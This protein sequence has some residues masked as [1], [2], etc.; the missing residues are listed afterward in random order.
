MVAET[1]NFT[2]AAE[3]LDVSQPSI[4]QQIKEIETLL[5]TV[6]FDRLGARVRLTQAGIAFRERAAEVV[7]KFARACEVV[8][9]VEGLLLGHVDVGVIPAVQIPWIPPVLARFAGEH[10]GVSIRVHERPSSDVETEV[11]AGRYDVGVGLM[12]RASPNLRYERIRIDELVLLA[13]SNHPLARRRDVQLRDLEEVRLALHPE[14]YPMRQMIEDAFRKARVR[15]RVAFEIDTIDSL[16]ATAARGPTPTILPSAVLD[17]R[18]SLG[19]RPIRIS[20]W[21]QKIE[22]GLM[23]PGTGEAGPTAKAFASVLREV[24]LG[25]GR[26]RLRRGAASA[27]QKPRSAAARR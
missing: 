20:S 13:A 19:L 1:E 17:G 15:P 10:P 6:L 22:L 2:R 21:T 7:T 5:A 23:W 4:S 16:L 24:A 26:R 11:E 9:H 27:A 18:E 8:E 14:S 25:Y 3:R 12:T